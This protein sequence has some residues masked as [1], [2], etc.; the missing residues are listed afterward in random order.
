MGHQQHLSALSSAP[1]PLV[2]HPKVT[3][4][5]PVDPSSPTVTG[6]HIPDPVP[7]FNEASDFK[8]SM[9]VREGG[10]NSE[11]SEPEFPETISYLR[12][13]SDRKVRDTYTIAARSLM[14]L[15]RPAAPRYH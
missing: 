2:H 7:L 4:P 3:Q 1:L 15:W 14:T 6:S 10:Y 9:G 13:K 11:V 5:P 8:G 12:M